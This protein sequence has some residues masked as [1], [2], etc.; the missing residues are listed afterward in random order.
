MLRSKGELEAR[1]R[2]PPPDPP[3]WGGERP[4]WE[5]RGAEA[6]GVCVG[7]F[8]LWVGGALTGAGLALML[9]GCA[10]GSTCVAVEGA[11]WGVSAG[12]CADGDRAPELG[13]EETDDGESP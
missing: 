10:I 4:A 13:Q 9:S 2:R 1:S 12:V 5:R 6:G 8:W 7:R 11:R 3:T